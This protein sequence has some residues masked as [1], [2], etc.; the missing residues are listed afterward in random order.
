MEALPNFRSLKSLAK[1]LSKESRDNFIFRGL[2][3]T[4]D[5]YDAEGQVMTYGN[6]SKLL[7]ISCITEDRYKSRKDLFCELEDMVFDL[8]HI[9]YIN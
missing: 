7:T 1:H 9:Q 8:K 5:Y 4:L 2:W 3:F 6:K